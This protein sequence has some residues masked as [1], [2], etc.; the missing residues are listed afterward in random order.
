MKLNEGTPWT[1]AEL[2]DLRKLHKDHS[3]AYLA[4][5]F[6]RSTGA[7]RKKASRMGLKKSAKYMRSLGK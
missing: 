4:R 5:R 2:V 3:A 1:K 6:G 7:I